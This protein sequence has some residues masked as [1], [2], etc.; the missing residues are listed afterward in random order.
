MWLQGQQQMALHVVKGL[1]QDMTFIQ[2]GDQGAGSGGRDQ[3]PGVDLVQLA[4]ALSLAGKWMSEVQQ[5]GGGTAVLDYLKRAS[6]CLPKED[7]TSNGSNVDLHGSLNG[8]RS[9]VGLHQISCKI[10]YRLASHADH[11]YREI[12]LQKTSPEFIRQV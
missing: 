6:D 5:A 3:S 2:Q 1:V 12:C 4:A 7:S 10:L 8:S 11:R 9:S